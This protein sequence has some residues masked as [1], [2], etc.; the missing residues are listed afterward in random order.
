MRSQIA[1]ILNVKGHNRMALR[2]MQCGGTARM[3]GGVS[4]TTCQLVWCCER[5]AWVRSRKA[6]DLAAACIRHVHEQ[7]PGGVFLFF[8]VVVPRMK[9]PARQVGLIKKLLKAGRRRRTSSLSSVGGSFLLIEPAKSFS[10][11]HWDMHGHGLFYV[12]GEAV[13]GLGR[14]Q[15]SAGAEG[16]SSVRPRI[17][18]AIE[19]GLRDAVVA[20]AASQGIQIAPTSRLGQRLAH[21]EVLSAQRS[22][23]YEGRRRVLA[24]QLEDDARRIAE[25]AWAPGK[26]VQHEPLKLTAADHVLLQLADMGPCIVRSGAFRGIPRIERLI[27]EARARL[28]D[29]RQMEFESWVKCHASGMEEG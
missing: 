24:E 7:D 16:A 11:G 12:P 10:H 8:T 6:G 15:R 27:Q 17:L 13:P 1:A 18:T 5:C 29:D 3:L 19:I 14:G 25:Y 23:L 20:A 9:D 4:K 22:W 28:P 2:L 21:V 26:S